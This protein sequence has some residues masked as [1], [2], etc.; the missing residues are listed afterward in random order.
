MWGS[1][2]SHVEDEAARRALGGDIEVM[3]RG[4]VAERVIVVHRV[5]GARLWLARSEQSS[6]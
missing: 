2:W 4:G 1:S 6:L 3:R 5:C